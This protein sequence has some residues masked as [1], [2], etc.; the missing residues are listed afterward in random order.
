[1]VTCMTFPDHHPFARSEIEPLVQE[2]KDWGAEILV[3]TEKDGVRLRKYRPL[4]RHIWEL[5]I[6]ATIM[7]PETLWKTYILKIMQG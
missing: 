5:R 7:A 1:V 3:T 6:R 2:A 4:P